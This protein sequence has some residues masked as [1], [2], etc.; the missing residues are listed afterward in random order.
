MYKTIMT[1]L[2]VVLFLSV[3][4]VPSEQASVAAFILWGIWCAAAMFIANLIFKHLQEE[5]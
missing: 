4:C 1:I 5:D 2:A 3:I